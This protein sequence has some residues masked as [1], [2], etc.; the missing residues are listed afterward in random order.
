MVAMT[1]EA[2]R[3]ALALP[4]LLLGIWLPFRKIRLAEVPPRQDTAC[5]W[6][7]IISL[8]FAPAAPN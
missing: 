8:L 4:R 1:A 2:L 7:Q 5:R 3:R 6:T